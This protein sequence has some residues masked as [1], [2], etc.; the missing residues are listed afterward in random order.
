MLLQQSTWPE[1]ERYLE[2][3]PG[4]VIPIGST[5][6]HGPNGLIGTDALC[7]EA[8]AHGVA[9]HHAVL[10][11]PTLAL[12]VAQFNLSFPGTISVRAAT[13]M[14]LV[15][16]V[17]H[18]LA[19]HGFRRVYFLNGH[20]G[21]IAPLRA[22]FQDIY[23]PHSLGTGSSP[24]RCRLRSWWEYPGTN[25]LRQSLYGDC[26]GLHATPSEVAITQ[27]VHREPVDA[28]PM[29][30]PSKLDAV[31]LRDRAGDNHYDANEHRHRFPDGR[32]G[33][34]PQLATAEHGARLLAL[35][36]EEAFEDYRVFLAES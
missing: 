16:D 11:G 15:E 26:E 33:S 8:I 1:I 7:A 14:A 28:G 29:A 34:A 31:F 13:L 2:R 3:S 9:Q 5:E 20:G 10:I 32:V 27:H 25:A 35:A 6:Q 23:W 18:S 19:H 24:V 22:V 21:N 30:L 17:V 36:T 4:I 12:G